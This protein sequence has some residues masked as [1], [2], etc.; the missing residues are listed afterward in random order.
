MT[1]AVFLDLDGTLTDSSGPITTSIALTLQELG[2]KVPETDVLRRLI[3]PALINTF[4]ALK[5]PDPSKALA[6]Y[7]THYVGERMLNAPVYEGVLGE[8][9]QMREAGHR[10]YLM[11][12]KPH[13]YA[14][15]ITAHLG[16]A[17]FLT[18]EYGPELDGRFNDKSELLKHALSETGEN[19]HRAVMVGDRSSDL[20]AGQSVSM[21][22]IAALWGYGDAQEMAGADVMLER[23]DGLPQAVA[24]LIGKETHVH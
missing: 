8:L 20:R 11:T 21:P 24:S 1:G 23:P 4:A 18:R 19:P 2:L 17:P 13:V 22:V 3:G 7:R 6:I 16:L 12:A 14:R 5:A 9:T 10:L 15:R